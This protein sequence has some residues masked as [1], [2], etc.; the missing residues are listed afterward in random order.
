MGRPKKE[1][2]TPELN[3]V[4]KAKKR[5]D[6][7]NA[8]GEEIRRE[9]EDKIVAALEDNGLRTIAAVAKVTTGAIRDVR[10]K[11]GVESPR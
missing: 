4:A 6:A 7:H 2:N 8:K 10:I 11:R 9:Y 3:E 5:L 1:L